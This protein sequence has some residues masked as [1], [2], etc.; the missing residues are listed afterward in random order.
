VKRR[1]KIRE[2]TRKKFLPKKPEKPVRCALEAPPP[3]F[4]TVF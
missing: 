3:P 4:K 1:E 2:K